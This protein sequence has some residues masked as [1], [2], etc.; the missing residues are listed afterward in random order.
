MNMVFSSGGVAGTLF[1]LRFSFKYSTKDKR[2]S[3]CV[4]VFG[5]CTCF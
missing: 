1:F 3:A 4:I 5:C 2:S